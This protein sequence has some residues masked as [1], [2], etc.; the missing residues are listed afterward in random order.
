MDTDAPP[1]EVC[2]SLL[3]AGRERG[4][5][6]E[7]VSGHEASAGPEASVRRPIVG[8]VRQP[9]QCSRSTSS[10]LVGAERRYAGEA[11]CKGGFHRRR[12]NAAGTSSADRIST[13][14]HHRGHA[15][16]HRQGTFVYMVHGISTV[17]SAGCSGLAARMRRPCKAGA[18]WKWMSGDGLETGAGAR[19]RGHGEI[20]A[21]WHGAQAEGAGV[22]EGAARW[23]GCTLHR[24]LR[25]GGRDAVG[26][27]GGRP[28][29]A[30]ACR[31]VNGHGSARC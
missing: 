19:G 7:C 24:R 16:A 10:W 21:T 8:G 5:P 3:A 28:L 14:A 20:G 9:E 15:V 1:L 26:V 25:G 12:K 17:S 30:G 31:A 4:H 13:A 11:S 22:P 18:R 2:G 27:W 29:G 6:L 23:Q